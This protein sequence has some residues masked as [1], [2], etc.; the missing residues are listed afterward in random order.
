[1]LVKYDPKTKQIVDIYEP[2][3]AFD[4]KV[5]GSEKFM[6]LGKNLLEAADKLPRLPSKAEIELGSFRL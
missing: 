4:M 6:L 1:M 2:L 5:C 3:D